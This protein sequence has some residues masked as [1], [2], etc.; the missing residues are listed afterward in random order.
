MK[1]LKF[2]DEFKREFRQFVFTKQVN[3]ENSDKLDFIFTLEKWFNQKLLLSNYTSVFNEFVFVYI[4]SKNTKTPDYFSLSRKT[5]TYEIG[6]NLD[7]MNFLQAEHNSIKILAFAFLKA[8]QTFLMNRKDFNGE[9]FYE[10]VKNLFIQENLIPKN[11]N[12]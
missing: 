1:N 4:L 10:D 2:P 12:F 5:K 6:K 11:E 9:K 3:A 7:Y 8:I